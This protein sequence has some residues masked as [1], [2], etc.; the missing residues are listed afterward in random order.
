MATAATLL[1]VGNRTGEA[2]VPLFF[3]GSLRFV[4]ESLYMAIGV[5]GSALPGA[6]LFHIERVSKLRT[7]LGIYCGFNLE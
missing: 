5:S 4:R 7:C 1:A 2:S 3:S 6:D